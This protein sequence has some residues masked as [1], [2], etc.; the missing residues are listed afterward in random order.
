MKRRSAWLAMA[1]GLVLAGCATAPVPETD[2]PEQSWSGRLAV[3]VHSAPPQ[4]LSA[5]FELNGSPT[6]GELRLFSPLGTTLAIVRWRPGQAQLQRGNEWTDAG[7]LHTLSE[8]LLGTDVPVTALFDWLNG[9]ATAVPGW[10]ADLSRLD[11][12]RLS[13]TRQSPLPAADLRLVL[14]R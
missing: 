2:R 8:G 11:D 3:Q 9:Q 1:C 14:D 13:A 10:Q 4:S 12:G 5:G 6:V 7:S